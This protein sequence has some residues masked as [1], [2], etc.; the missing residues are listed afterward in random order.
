MLMRPVF[1]TNR[2]QVIQINTVSPIWKIP[3]DV[4]QADPKVDLLLDS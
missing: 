4:A 3:T 2:G 1:A